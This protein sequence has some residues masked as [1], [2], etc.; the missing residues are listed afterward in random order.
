MQVKLLRAIQEKRV[1]KVGAT[2]EE[3][4]D[5]RVI[6][7]TNQD[8][9]TCVEAGG[10][11]QD[12][13]YRLNVIE[14]R[15]PP[16]RECR[17]DIATIAGKLLERLARENGVRPPQ[18]SAAAL[19][20]LSEYDF[21]GNVRELENILERAIALSA[22]GEIEVEDLRLQP[23]SAEERAVQAQAGTALP[24]AELP[25]APLPL[26]LDQVEREAILAALAKTG[27]KRAAAATLLGL[28]LRTL[29]YRMQRLGIRDPGG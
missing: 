28:T 15:M 25:A 11:R 9:S 26:Y 27:F 16:L 6:S 7:A 1:R 8:L 22:G 4:V 17:E 24:G 21:P 18:F 20:R 12:L 13:Y 23:A 3:P 5:V 10:F 19:A 2:Q 29:R 14:L